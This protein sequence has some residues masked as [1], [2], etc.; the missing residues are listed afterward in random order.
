MTALMLAAS[1]NRIENVEVL[2]AR[3]ANAD[4]VN[5][6]NRKAVQVNLSATRAEPTISFSSIFAG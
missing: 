1:R 2:L 6:V 5:E 4:I 3:G